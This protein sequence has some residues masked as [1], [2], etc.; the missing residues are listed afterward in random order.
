MD[1]WLNRNNAIIA[2]SGI[3][4]LL[5][6]LIIVY[7]YIKSNYIVPYASDKYLQQLNKKRLPEKPFSLY[8]IIEISELINIIFNKFVGDSPSGLFNIYTFHS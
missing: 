5:I 6:E 1:M 3:S 4:F 7:K 2:N 8:S